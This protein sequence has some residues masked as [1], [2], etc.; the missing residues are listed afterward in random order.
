MLIFNAA[1]S[2]STDEVAVSSIPSGLITVVSLV[3]DNSIFAELSEVYNPVS[4][5]VNLPI[6]PEVDII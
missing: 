5:I 3:E 1:Y 6:E 2:S 4:F